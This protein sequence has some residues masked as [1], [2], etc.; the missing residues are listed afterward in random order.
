M[1]VQVWFQCDSAPTCWSCRS[2]AERSSQRPLLI[3]N[4]PQSHQF[5]V[6]LL[7]FECVMHKKHMLNTSSHSCTHQQTSALKHPQTDFLF[8]VI[9]QLNILL[10]LRQSL[11]PNSDL[12]LLILDKLLVTWWAWWLSINKR[13]VLRGQPGPLNSALFNSIWGSQVDHR[14]MRRGQLEGRWKHEPERDWG[15]VGAWAPHSF[16]L[17]QVSSYVMDLKLIQI[18]QIT[19]FFLN[20]LKAGSCLLTGDLTVTDEEPEEHHLN[21]RDRKPES[22]TTWAEHKQLLTQF[23]LFCRCSFAVLR[24]IHLRSQRRSW[25]KWV[26]M[27]E[28][29]QLCKCLLTLRRRRRAVSTAK[30]CERNLGRNKRSQHFILLRVLRSCQDGLLKAGAKPG[31]DIRKHQSFFFY[32]ADQIQSDLLKQ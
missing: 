15:Y 3:I 4:T 18:K 13:C 28:K 20:R 6:L 31:A 24:N 12:W 7:V 17:H 22:S 19:I 16:N 23:A 11:R 21:V 30:G 5:L 10:T 27:L 32:Q 29:H 9:F 14:W 25:W 2:S 8:S 1:W 26:Q